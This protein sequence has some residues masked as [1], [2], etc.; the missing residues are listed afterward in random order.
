MQVRMAVGDLG[1]VLGANAML[2][3]IDNDE[4][5]DEGLDIPDSQ[6]IGHHSCLLVHGTP[7]RN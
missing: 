3:S 2:G 4:N 7:V 1:S 5:L 6:G